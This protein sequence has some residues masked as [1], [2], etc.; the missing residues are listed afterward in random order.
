MLAHYRYSVKNAL[1]FAFP[2]L[3]FE[4]EYFATKRA[5]IIQLLYL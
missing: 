2:D 1:S 4:E 3:H 5:Y